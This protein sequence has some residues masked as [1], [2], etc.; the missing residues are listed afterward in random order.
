MTEDIITVEQATSLDGLFYKR[1][2]RTPDKEALRY[3]D[4]GE[5]SWN[6]YTWK[7]SLEEVARWQE[8]LARENLS[9]GD[10]VAILLRNCPEWVFFEQAALSLGLVVVPL[11]TDDRPDNVGYIIEDAGIRLLLIQD[12][13]RWKRLAPSV[14]NENNPLQR[15]LIMEPGSEADKCARNDDR[16]HLIENEIPALGVEYKPRQGGDINS[17]ATIVYTSGTTGRPKGVMLSHYN[18]LSIAHSG[19]TMIS[20]FVEDTF[21]SFLPLSHTLERTV[22]YYV[23]VMTGACIVYA[24][25]VGQLAEDL[26]DHKPTILIAVPRVFERVYNKIQDQLSKGSA[27][28][29]K[30]FS[31]AV[32]IGWRR[33]EKDQGRA[34]WH[35]SLL[36][37]KVLDKLVGAKIRD[38]LGGNMRIAVAGGAP[39]PASIGEMFISL[40][41]PVLQGY[42]LTETAPIISGNPIERNK[43]ASVGLPLRGIDVKVGESEELLVKTPGMMLG[44]WNNH[45]ATSNVIDKDGWLHTGD[46]GR[47]DEDGHIFIT[48]RLKDILVLSN[49]EKIPPAEMESAINMDSMFDQVMVIGEGESYL[50]A[51]AVVDEAFWTVSAPGKPY[52]KEALN[53]KEVVSDALKRMRNALHDFPGYAKVRRV[54]LLSEPWGIDNGMMTPTLKVKRQSVLEHYVD[55]VKSMYS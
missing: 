39:L 22:G 32:K 34:G 25:S 33:F 50:T 36:A 9:A 45:D 7:E 26:V 6:S 41:V 19:M 23:P 42:G 20:V 29:R 12:A 27:V 54:V 44:Y 3:F 1:S 31:T 5:K 17:L 49:G 38:K 51:L 11:Y 55:D 47:I 37:H 15:V 4:K 43:P 30:L 10:R 8:M 28:K 21:L 48:G 13:G 24:R 53:Q 40:G 18:I 14:E 35:P 46:Q 52:T 2:E 16:V